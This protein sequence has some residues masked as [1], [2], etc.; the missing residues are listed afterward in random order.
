MPRVYL[1]TSF[2]SACV[3][4]RTD[5]PSLY[6]RE[7]SREW[8][9]SQGPRHER[10]VSAEVIAELSAPGYSQGAEALGFIAELPLLAIDEE[11]RGL[12]QVL[13]QERV[14]PG[15]LA[16]DAIH[17]AVASWH[18]M[19]YLL[20]WNVRHLANPNK[21]VHLRTVCLRLGTVPPRILTPDILWEI[22]DDQA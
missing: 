5:T 20:S 10:F 9:S 14:M 12:A 6:R 16:G 11:V 19:D 3:T 13:I 1:D 2:V 7:L 18:A 4:T 21:L 8:W 22:D 17:V 15:P